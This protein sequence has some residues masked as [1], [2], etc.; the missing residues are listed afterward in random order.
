MPRG[1]ALYVTVSGALATERFPF[2]DPAFVRGCR[3]QSKRQFASS[4]KKSKELF[5][6]S[7]SY[8][9][10]VPTKGLGFV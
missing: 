4:A 2:G 1:H 7:D 8:L 6:H 10:S 9:Y 3:A 5:A